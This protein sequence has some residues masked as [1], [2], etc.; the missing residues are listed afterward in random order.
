MEIA[1]FEKVKGDGKG[2]LAGVLEATA[3]GAGGASA[4]RLPERECPGTLLGAASALT[5][6]KSLE[7]DRPSWGADVSI[8]RLSAI[9]GPAEGWD[10][11]WD[12]NW[13]WDWD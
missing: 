3:R 1:G 5:R 11:D 9:E 13:G 4:T 10:W 12:W 8:L 7:L 2:E 6:L